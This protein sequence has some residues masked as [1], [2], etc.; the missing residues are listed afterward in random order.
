MQVPSIWLRVLAST[1]FTGVTLLDK[2][3]SKIIVAALEH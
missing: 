2:Q 1:F 3:L